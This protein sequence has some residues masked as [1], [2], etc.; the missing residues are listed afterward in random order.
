MVTGG[1]RGIGFA[2]ARSLAMEGAAVA[3]CGRAEEATKT[4]VEELRRTTGGRVVGRALDVRQSEE[5][6]TYFEFVEAEL[7]RVDVLVNN[8]GIGIFSA[9][10]DLSFEDWRNTLDTNLSGV[11]Y[12]CREALPR[13]RRVGSGY[14]VNIS[15]LAGRNP[16][17]GGAAYNASKF[18]VN[19][20]TE[21][22]MQEVRAD[23]IKVSLICP[24]SVN[25]E[26]GNEEI[27]Q[28]KAW[29]IQPADIAQ[30]VIDLLNH[31]ARVLPSKIEI[32]PSKPPKK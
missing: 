28:E 25:T 32:R 8:A 29:Q 11:F 27:S 9:V 24:G 6:R 15:S 1:T 14:I 3:I 12:C 20:F 10:A 18:A 7:G 4:A 30:V 19:G 31:N 22:L 21:A 17:A 5:V 26:F 16:M 23:N 2:I 13:M